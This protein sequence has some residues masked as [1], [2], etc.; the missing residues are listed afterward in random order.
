MPNGSQNYTRPVVNHN[1]YTLLFPNVAGN[2]EFFSDEPPNPY[3]E[4]IYPKYPIE[5]K[6]NRGAQ[7]W[8]Y[9]K[10]GGSALA[11]AAPLQGAA[12]I[13]AEADDDIVVGA[14]SAIGAYT[15]TLTSTA[16]LATSP[17]SVKD[18][19]AEGYLIVNDEAGE[20]YLYKIKGH[21]AASGTANFIVTLYDPIAVALTAVS[22][23][24]LAENPYSRVIVTAAPLSA[25]FIG[26]SPIVVTANYYFW[27]HTSGP[28][29]IT[30]GE[31]I[32][33]GRKVCVGDIAAQANAY[34]EATTLGYV[35]GEAITPG[36]AAGEHFIV[37]LNR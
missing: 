17:L 18:G 25:I 7:E 15:V 16:N 32:T 36:V 10:N 19:F 26:T 8:T 31:A 4:S 23:V 28:A 20:K 11:A 33:R 29:P 1:G 37:N 24:G 21:E 34:D 30:A 3:A 5:S 2:D 14:A 12:V 13:H 27:A 6:V 35:I 22:Q 9:C